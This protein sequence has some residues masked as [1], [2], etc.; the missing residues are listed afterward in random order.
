MNW[1]FLKTRIT[2]MSLEAKRA[3]FYLQGQTIAEWARAHSF[4]QELVYAVL[5]GRAKGIRGES[6]RVAVA[7]GLKS[8]SVDA[9]DADSPRG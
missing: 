1:L 2:P 6:H 8:V 5:S 4:R 9:C 3:E 7:L